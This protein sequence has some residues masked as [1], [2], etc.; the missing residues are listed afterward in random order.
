MRFTRHLLRSVLL[1]V[2]V[3]NSVPVLAAPAQTADACAVTVQPGPNSY[4]N[5]QVSVS[6]LWPNGTVVFKPGGP[7]FITRDGSL[8][9]PGRAPRLDAGLLNPGQ[10]HR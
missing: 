5:Q 2:M 6:G 7:G 9:T 3:V 1:L 8:E 10:L 4:G